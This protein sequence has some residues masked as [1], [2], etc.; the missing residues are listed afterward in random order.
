M[1]KRFRIALL[2][3]HM[4]FGIHEYMRHKS[5]YI[6]I[7][8]NPVDR[9]VSH[10][11]YV[12][13]NPKHYLYDTVQ[14]YRMNLKEYVQSGI[15]VELDNDQVRILAGHE[16]KNDFGNC[17]DQ[18]LE[19]AK[20]NVRRHFAVCGISEKFDKTILEIRRHLRWLSLPLYEKANVSVNRPTLNEISEETLDCIDKVN[21]LDRKLFEWAEIRFDCVNV[22]RIEINAFK[23]VNWY[24]QRLMQIRNT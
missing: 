15:S 24:F 10:Y 16:N 19:T 3:G 7:L 12:L 2:K 17:S 9:V 1:E 18:L 6:T 11:Y 23:M 21:H 14:K 5:E 22:P 20:E 4:H 8:R 13:R